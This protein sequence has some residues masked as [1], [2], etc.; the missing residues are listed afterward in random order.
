MKPACIQAVQAAAGRLLTQSEIKKIDDRI[1][2]TMRNM[3]RADPAGWRAR[4]ADQRV[5]DAAQQAMGDIQGEAALK[6]WRAQVQI[7][8]TSAMESRIGDLMGT[9][10]TSRT[11]SFM[12]EMQ[13]TS[14]YIEGVKRE[15]MSHMGDLL[16]AVEGKDGAGVMRRGMM[17]LLDAEN[18][19]MSQDLA[20]EIKDNA[21]GVTGNQL[22]QR[23][24]KAWLAGI[25]TFRQRFN[26]AGGDIGKLDYGYLPQPHDQGRVRGNATPAARDKWVQ[27]ILP[28]LDRNHYFQE[29]GTRMT[30]VQ[31]TGLFEGMWKTIANDGLNK[32]VPGQGGTGNGARANAGSE[33]RQ[34]HF[35]DGAAYLE[36]M[37]KYGG[38]SMYD[39]MVGHMSRLSRDIGLVERYG[40]NPNQQFRLQN[41]LAI[42]QDGKRSGFKV[43][44]QGLWNVLSG[45]SGSSEHA[46]IAQIGQHIRNVEVFGKLGGAMVTSLTDIP[47]YFATSG[48]NNLGY[49]EALKNIP[50]QMDGDTRDFLSMHGIIADSMLS[51][52]A[53]WSG[54]NIGQSWSGRLANSTMKLSLLNAWTDTLRRAFSMTMMA[55]LGKLSKLEWGRLSEYDQ[56]RMKAKGLTEDDWSVIRQAQLTQ[57]KG[58]DFLTPEAIHASGDPRASEVV[59][60]VLGLITDESEYAVINPNLMT[61]AMQSWGG[62]SRG[63]LDGELARFTMQFKSFPIAM[64]SRHWGRLLETP[65]GMQGA[66]IMANRL[67]YGA[68][69]LGVA[70][71]ILGGIVTQTKEVLLGKDPIDMS[72]PKFW[73]KAFMQGGGAGFLGDVLMRDSSS[74]LSSQQGLF[75]LLG[76]SFGSAAALWDLTK[77]NID[78]SIAGK[79]PHVGA[80]AIRFGKGH[81]PYL[82]LWYARTAIDHM[83]LH[84]IQE[85]LSPGYL[86]K[87]Q[88]RAQKNWGNDY[89]YRPDSGSIFTGD[90]RGPERAPDLTA[91]GGK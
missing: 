59:A 9:L 30:D 90:M 19:K 56:W 4:S 28:G 77:G 50:R 8:K 22:A 86:S 13:Q 26:A 76:P 32:I 16:E 79:D 72:K 88:Q 40:P 23:G 55:G 42:Q 91:I 17:F 20:V 83:G 49:W 52:L 47:S 61:K 18:P 63:T 39:A 89:W 71:T 38:G 3:A 5:M 46:N 44:P 7:I 73:W 58:M 64:I 2:A 85:N 80:E 45:A 43:G 53:R 29:D 31:M 48:Y 81:L 12:R 1:S 37:S 65:Q 24:A 25:E 21:T 74:D 34:I 36:Y 69:I 33:S 11:K 35:K 62:K 60:K 51:D 67:V 14:N 75:E 57:H 78:Q 82:N 66:P 84:A 15:N 10:G 27:D 54:D 87:M 70:S 68:G 41:D 6:I